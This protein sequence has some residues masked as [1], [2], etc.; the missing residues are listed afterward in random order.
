MATHPTMP[1]FGLICILPQTD[2]F[3]WDRWQELRWTS[4]VISARHLHPFSMPPT[5]TK[6]RV[7]QPSA[8]PPVGLRLPPPQFA[9]IVAIVR[10]EPLTLRT[11]EDVRGGAV[12]KGTED[13]RQLQLAAAPC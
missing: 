4:S 9:V 2:I 10:R 1:Q 6:S 11:L 12:A 5:Q 13:C 7:R 8:K 3:H